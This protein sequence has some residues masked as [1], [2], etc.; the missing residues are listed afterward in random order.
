M[1]LFLTAA[2]LALLPVTPVHAA[3]DPGS[4]LCRGGAFTI[5]F[6]PDLTFTEQTVTLEADGDL[7]QCE[8]K[9]HPQ[10]TGGAFHAEAV[11]SGKCPG[12]LGPAGIEV[13]FLWNDGSLSATDDA[14]FAANGPNWVM[15]P[16][17]IKTGPFTRTEFHAYGTTDAS[18]LTFNRICAKT[19]LP[20]LGATTEQLTLGEV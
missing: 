15:T 1:R 4:I 9:S 7:G 13:T 8:S 2:T 16:G 11:F 5:G 19:G 17:H 18:L 10:I 12:P 6:T 14:T 20:G 3:D